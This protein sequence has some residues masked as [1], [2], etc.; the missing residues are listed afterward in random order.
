MNCRETVTCVTTRPHAVGA[1]WPLVRR[2]GLAVHANAAAPAVG[3]QSN[4]ERPFEPPTRSALIPLPPGAVEPEGWLRDW[5][6]TAKDGY[7][8]HMDERRS[9]V[10]SGLGKRL[11]NDRRP[12]QLVGYAADGPTRAAATGS[13]GSPSW[14]IVL[15]DKALIDQAKTRLGV[16]VDNMNPNSIVFMWWL[17]KNK[18]EDL[19]AVEG[20]GHCGSRNGRCGPTGLM[21]RSLAG[22][23]AG[24]GDNRILKT[25]ETA[26]SGN[27][28]LGRLGLV[29]VESLARV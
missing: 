4:Y 9:R 16:V 8:S 7:T 29:D 24:S 28:R 22:Y 21:G 15:H 25:L 6:I 12:H 11:Q 19:K 1:V 17:N 26:Y 20:R 10:S 3:G 27:P 18:P 14:A 23:Y 5:C 13:K 2:G